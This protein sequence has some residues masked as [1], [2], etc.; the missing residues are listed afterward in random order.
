MLRATLAAGG[1]DLSVS[2]FQRLVCGELA[3]SL[4]VVESRHTQVGSKRV[5]HDLRVALIQT[6][7]PD[8]RRASHLGVEVDGELS[9]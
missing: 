6:S 4:S 1:M 5:L 3:Q 2:E 7:G 9:F 8:L